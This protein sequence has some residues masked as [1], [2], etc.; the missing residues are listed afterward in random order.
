MFVTNVNI[1]LVIALT[2]PL[3]YSLIHWWR[4][5][6]GLMTGS[7]P[8]LIF[9]QSEHTEFHGTYCRFNPYQKNIIGKSY[10]LKSMKSVINFD[11]NIDKI[12]WVMG[13]MWSR[14]YRYVL[15]RI[16][17]QTSSHTRLHSALIILNVEC[18]NFVLSLK[19]LIKLPQ[20][21]FWQ[22]ILHLA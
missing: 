17:V 20:Q 3:T 13:N 22:L 4:L 15:F 16:N 1:R 12:Y 6:A 9:S 21:V 8:R 7:A 19:L 2:S 18:I 5:Q 11:I 10:I 14:C